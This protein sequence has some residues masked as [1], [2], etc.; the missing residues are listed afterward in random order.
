MASPPWEN[1]EI[2]TLKGVFK[3]AQIFEHTFAQIFEHTFA[4]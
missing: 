2:S 4:Q 1:V 3:F